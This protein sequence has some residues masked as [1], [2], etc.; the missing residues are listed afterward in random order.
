MT[1]TTPNGETPGAGNSS[2]PTGSK[3]ILAAALSDPEFAKTLRAALFPDGA[4]N[5]RN[6]Q[7]GSPDPPDQEHDN[8][9]E[10]EEEEEV[11]ET[12]EGEIDA[13]SEQ[14]A[15]SLHETQAELREARTKLARME[16]RQKNADRT[17]AAL[18]EKAKQL[19]DG[20]DRASN[21]RPPRSTQSK[22]PT[23]SQG[24]TPRRGGM[25]AGP[26]VA[27]RIRNR[28]K[29]EE[30]AKLSDMKPGQYCH[31]C[32]HPQHIKPLCPFKD[33]PALEAR[34]L[35]GYSHPPADAKAAGK[36]RSEQNDSEP[37]KGKIASANG[38]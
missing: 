6:G 35:S 34:E 16:T 2:D 25:A 13:S 36:R 4:L 24:R 7:D 29:L 22:P 27:Y 14:L 9:E 20:L 3:A 28:A 18:A 26:D 31:H 12:S 32:Y 33:L 5:A 11:N 1:D 15:Q 23:Q 37:K 30:A 21:P 10:Q 8:E 38:K 19:A 17:I